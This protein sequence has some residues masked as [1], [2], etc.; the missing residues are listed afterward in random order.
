MRPQ[1]TVGLTLTSPRMSS[2]TCVPAFCAAWPTAKK[3]ALFT[4]ECTVMCSSP[5]K[6]AMGP[7][8]PKAKVTSPMCSMEE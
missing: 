7:A 6:L 5:A 4:S 8:M 1:P 3:M 2:I